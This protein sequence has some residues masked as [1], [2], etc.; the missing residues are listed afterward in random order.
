[1]LT[2]IAI[3]AV[4]LLFGPA[5]VLAS[6]GFVPVTGPAMAA[7]KGKQGGNSNG[8][9]ANSSNA[10]SAIGGADRNAEQ[11]SGSIGDDF[12]N[13]GFRPPNSADDAPASQ[14]GREGIEPTGA[15]WNVGFGQPEKEANWSESL[16][17]GK[18]F[19][20]DFLKN[21]P[22]SDNFAIAEQPGGDASKQDKGHHSGQ[23][24]GHDA[25]GAERGE[26]VGRGEQDNDIAEEAAQP[27]IRQRVSRSP[28]RDNSLS[29]DGA[30]S[31]PP[32][33]TF[34]AREVLALDLSKTSIDRIR[35]LGFDL[36]VSSPSGDASALTT[37]IAPRTL[38]ALEALALL[39]RELPAEQFHLNRLYR[40]YRLAAGEERAAE[41]TEAA[42]AGKVTPCTNDKCYARSA[43]QWTDSFA[44]CAR[45]IA[46][47]VIDTDVDL[48]HPT[49]ARQ[50][51]ARKSFLPAGRQAAPKW[52]GTGVLAL[53]AGRP[54]S[55]TPGLIHES[56]F[57]LASVFFANDDG[58][59]VTD[60]VSLLAA[61][62]W[63]TVSGARL[64]NMSFS[65]PQD[66]LV[67][68]RIETMRA[69]GFVFIA[70]VGNE[71]PAAAP[72]YPAAYPEVVAV[73]AVNKDL[74]I[75]LSANRGAQ[76]DF[77]APGVRIW[78]ALPDAREG[79]RSG[80]SFAVP[81]A[82]AVLALQAED[83]FSVPKKDLLAHVK[84]VSLGKPG[85]NPIYGRGL[86]QAPVKCLA[87]EK[88]VSYR[89][90]S[91]VSSVR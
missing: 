3:A 24:L 6:F 20:L 52:H 9:G 82:T 7:G 65:G 75:Y 25:A 35:E 30:L 51:I 67:Q 89:T 86:L 29:V 36:S 12:R 15:A 62:D 87:A 66:D 2:R 78:T 33:D 57:F 26:R 31:A 16:G 4:V 13:E 28:A 41:G 18:Q 88:E 34:V 70:A 5:L 39:R 44:E 77:A 19:T 49:F 38:G 64:V 42:R 46:V 22:G 90:S 63:M 61:L 68:A 76:I 37:L 60:T 73:T 58:E 69:Q 85:W 17:L 21:D 74:R 71:G 1:M 43:I 47:G 11:G 32:P 55:G 27:G 80:T 84:T 53:L 81:F 50:K 79:Y 40:P 14:Y 91:S 54:D 83:A 59:A 8:N 48:Q 72:A 45:N 23:E 56:N 10:G